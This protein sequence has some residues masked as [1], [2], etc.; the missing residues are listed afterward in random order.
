MDKQIVSP[1]SVYCDKCKQWKPRSAFYTRSGAPHLLLT[2]CK[3]CRIQMSGEQEQLPR[4]VAGN[5]AETLVIE[6]MA[7][8][9]IP[10]LPG[11]AFSVHWT[12]VIA[13]GSIPVEVKSS[14]WYEDIN[15]FK[16][17]FSPK[18]HQERV[19]GDAIVLV[20][21]YPDHN[22][23]HVLPADHKCFYNEHGNHKQG[24]FFVR[25]VNEA[26]KHHNR[27]ILTQDIMDEY[28]DDWE[29]IEIRRQQLSSEMI[30]GNFTIASLMPD[31]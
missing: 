10:A 17:S 29:R 31:K 12:D 28:E 9:G 27:N 8:F 7:Q 21:Q 24:L 15:G 5:S 19:L 4:T 23:F 1:D 6:R 13:W 26:I 25:G 30:V 11:K 2:P 16:F 3:A 20:C 14:S 22:T 18:Q